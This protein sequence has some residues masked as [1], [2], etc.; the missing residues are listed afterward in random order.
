MRHRKKL[1]AF[2]LLVLF[3][4]VLICGYWFWA[5]QSL[6]A[7]VARWIEKREAEGFAVTFS[8]SGTFGF[9]FVLDAQFVRPVI[10]RPDGWRWAGPEVLSG[11]TPLW[12]PNRVRLTFP[13]LHR[14]SHPESGPSATVDAQAETATAEARV[15]VD[16]EPESFQAEVAGL[17]VTNEVS[18]TLKVATLSAAYGP[19]IL[20]I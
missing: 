9:P 4:A 13:G 11:E 2:G 7:E 15:Q 1:I 3:G 20:S 6:N 14:V 10:V 8:E 18:G 12:A 19:P 5:K 17:A 16:G